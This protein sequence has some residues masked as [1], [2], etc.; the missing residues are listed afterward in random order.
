[1]PTRSRFEQRLAS[2]REATL[3]KS[4]SALDTIKDVSLAPGSTPA[5][6]PTTFES[7]RLLVVGRRAYDA[8]GTSASR[9]AMLPAAAFEDLLDSVEPSRDLVVETYRQGERPGRVIYAPE[10]IGRSSSEGREGRPP[11]RGTEDLA[12]D[13]HDV[14][15]YGRHYFEALFARRVD[16]WR[17]TNP[18]EQKK[19]EQILSLIPKEGIGRAIDLG[20]AEGHFTAR[21]AN[22]VP[23]VVAADISQVALDRAARRLKGL[24][25]VRFVRLDFASEPLPGRFDLIVCSEVLYYLE[26]REQLQAVARKLANALE[27]GGYL[28]TAHANQV[29][30]EPDEPGF[31]W[32]HLS[33]LK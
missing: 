11:A 21:L 23:S 29:V 12:D 33:E 31:D 13:P 18:Y 2:A 15:L 19:H 10:L 20:C 17:Y 30:D 3:A 25:N 6:D 8:I 27:P 14:P 24:E 26:G 32:G 16:P 1:M 28:L 22:R 9:R 7:E 5:F 4:G